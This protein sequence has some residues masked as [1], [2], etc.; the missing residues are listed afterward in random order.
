MN[1]FEFKS[2]KDFLNSYCEQERGSLS[3]LAEAGECQKSYLSACLKGKGQL[4]LDQAYGM[5]EHL[6]LSDFEQDYFFLL[7]EKEKAVT[8]KLRR[9]LEAKAKDMARESFRLKNQQKDSL[10][11]SE[12]SSDVGVYYATWLTTAIHTLTSIPRFQTAPMLAKRLNLTIET[13]TP[14]LNYLLKMQ[15][16]E[17][18]G[19]KYRWNSANIHLADNSTWI[20][21]HHSN[22][23]TRATENIQKHDK[24]ATH[25]SAVQSFSEQDFE[26]LKR[27]IA[28]FIT[29]FNKV[30]DPSDP[31]EAFCLNIDLFRV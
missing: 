10:I 28:G 24:E 19:D 22:W 6:E 8:P 12:V 7:I 20:S 4:S 25:Y 18:S 14:V 11:I 3:R 15:M 13:V 21:V 9:R 31:E 16:I 17:K 30:S 1:I 27:K 5:A 26:K 23:R 29:E 2:Y